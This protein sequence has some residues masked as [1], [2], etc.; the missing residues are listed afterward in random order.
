MRWW[1]FKNFLK[2]LFFHFIYFVLLSNGNLHLTKNLQKSKCRATNITD[3]ANREIALSFT[4]PLRGWIKAKQ[5]RCLNFKPTTRQVYGLGQSPEFHVLFLV[6]FSGREIW[7]WCT[8]W[9]QIWLSWLLSP[10]WNAV[11]TALPGHQPMT[12]FLWLL[13]LSLLFWF[14]LASLSLKC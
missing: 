3:V 4:F 2:L 6:L 8:L 7:S 14:L 10:F 9:K 13:T 1:F 12:S 5:S 11:F